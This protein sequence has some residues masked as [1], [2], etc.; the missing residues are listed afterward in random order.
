MVKNKKSLH[1]VIEQ[2]K[3]LIDYHKHLIEQLEIVNNNLNKK[4]SCEE[5][6]EDHSVKNVTG[7]E[8]VM[9]LEEEKEEA[10]GM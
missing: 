8:K 9:E 3:F 6:E 5:E 4:L 1:M 10:P 7:L 2:N